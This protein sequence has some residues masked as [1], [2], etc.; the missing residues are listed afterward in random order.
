MKIGYISNNFV[1]NVEFIFCGKEIDW[2][3]IEK[4]TKNIDKQDSIFESPSFTHIIYSKSTENKSRFFELT[5]LLLETILDE[6]GE[7]ELEDIIQIRANL[8]TKHVESNGK[9]TYPHQD[10]GDVKV[11]LYYVHDSDGPTHIFIDDTIN[12]IL[13]KKG[14]FILF[15]NELH[16]AA[17][18]VDNNLR[19]IL[20]YNLKLRKRGSINP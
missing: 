20:N 14:K 19:V 18:P 15:D 2:Y 12:K 16:A 4:T 6:I 9:H 11:L 17:F 10:D 8:M 7:Y 1:E 5:F 3:L 13:P